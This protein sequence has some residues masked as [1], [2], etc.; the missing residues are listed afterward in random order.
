MSETPCPRGPVWRDGRVEAWL[1][2]RRGREQWT[3]GEGGLVG[4]PVRAES[5]ALSVCGNGLGLA[6]VFLQLPRALYDHHW[7][8]TCRPFEGS[9][10]ASRNNAAGRFC[11]GTVESAQDA[12]QLGNHGARV[13]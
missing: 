13:S 6:T 7:T 3:A 11:R 12:R 1:A 2:E 9:A 10:H 5:N 8:G 4:V